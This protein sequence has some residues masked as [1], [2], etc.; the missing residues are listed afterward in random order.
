MCS[1]CHKY[2]KNILTI[3]IFYVISFLRIVAYLLG[4]VER[5]W[6]TDMAWGSR[7]TFLSEA[8][9]LSNRTSSYCIDIKTCIAFRLHYIT[10]CPDV[11]LCYIVFHFETLNVQNKYPIL[12]RGLFYSTLIMHSAYCLQI[13]LPWPAA[14][15]LD[16][17]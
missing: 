12:H 6:S 4:L 16:P 5:P 14:P 17:S 13:S 10:E 11:S 2:I 3:H 15:C 1:I 8:I 9:L 7:A